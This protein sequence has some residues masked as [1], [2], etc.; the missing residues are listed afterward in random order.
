MLQDQAEVDAIHRGV[1]SPV[2]RRQLRLDDRTNLDR[3]CQQLGIQVTTDRLGPVAEQEFHH[4]S[5]A[6]AEV[7]VQLVG[8]GLEKPEELGIDLGL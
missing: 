2:E 7:Q 1:S 6:A 3:S 5:A 4:S 8:L